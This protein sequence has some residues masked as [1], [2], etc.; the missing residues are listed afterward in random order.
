LFER[1]LGGCM[2]KFLPWLTSWAFFAGGYTL[3]SWLVSISAAN[4]FLIAYVIVILVFPWCV[5]TKSQIGAKA[6]YVFSFGAITYFVTLFTALLTGYVV[7]WLVD[8][9]SENLLNRQARMP[10]GRSSRWLVSALNWLEDVDEVLSDF[11]MK[12]FNHPGRYH[13]IDI[14]ADQTV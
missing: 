1:R 3:L 9:L 4:M 10:P 7:L 14:T 11:W 5:S 12:V 2:R 6:L 13:G 8:C